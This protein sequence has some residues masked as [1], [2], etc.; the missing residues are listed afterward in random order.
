MSVFMRNWVRVRQA[1]VEFP[2]SGFVA[3]LG[4]NDSSNGSVASI[5]AGKSALGEAISRA[6]FGVEGRFARLGWYSTDEKGDCY[7]AVQADLN[8]EELFVEMGFKCREINPDGEG[9]RWRL[10]KRPEVRC[11]TIEETRAQLSALLSVTEA[12]AQWT[13]HMDGEKLKFSRI[14]QADAVQLLFDVMD[15]PRWSECEGR[16]RRAAGAADAEASAAETSVT[17]ARRRVDQGITGVSEA[18]VELQSRRKEADAAAAI[19]RESKARRKAERAEAAGKL[20]DLDT[21]VADLTARI[22][23]A[24][25]SA[26]ASHKG[27]ELSAARLRS[28]ISEGKRVCQAWADESDKAV[29]ATRDAVRVVRGLRDAPE[30][31][32]TCGKAWDKRPTNVQITEAQAEEDRCSEYES[33]VDKALAEATEYV[34]GRRRQLTKVEGELD[35]ER[36]SAVGGLSEELERA[37]AE[38]SRAAEKIRALSSIAEIREDDMGVP[39]WTARLAERKETLAKAEATK[40]EME[41]AVATAR[42][43][44]EGCRYWLRAF[45]PSGI[46][47]LVLSS[48]I[49]A[50][51]DCAGA[52]ADAMTGGA[53]GVEFSTSVELA[54][55]EK[56][57]RLN[58]KSIVPF[59]ASRIAGTSK[60][61]GGVS[62]LVVA[63]AHA[64][65]GGMLGRVGYRW[66]DEVVNTQDPVVRGRVY[67]YYAKQAA[68]RGILIFAVDH[69]P[70]ARECA[71]HILVARK[72]ADGFTTYFWET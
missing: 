62:N 60:G 59:G 12:A 55:G 13:V 29:I 15:Q 69:Y 32:P 67:G 1:R 24:V 25:D 18:E 71:E 28:R 30:S 10:G 65:V 33:R 6:L 31:C 8:G 51:N 20:E 43:R 42:S 63:E 35:A 2:E 50:L 72:G 47:N 41:L 3:V 64:L 39:E 14:P 34:A 54:G 56:R 68:E 70:E 66:L 44:A 9:L 7:V 21:R 22:R 58:V 17:E 49:G 46:P 37:T 19:A 5:G 57:P 27:L 48:C 26:G 36:A 38:R 45:G 23:K 52:A 40:V 53:V 16:A 61:E 4:E 11:G